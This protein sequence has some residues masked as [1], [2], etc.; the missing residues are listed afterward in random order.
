MQGNLGTLLDWQVS[1]NISDYLIVLWA[2]QENRRQYR[3]LF[4]TA[5]IGGGVSGAILFEVYKALRPLPP[6]ANAP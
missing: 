1:V 4:Y 3:E 5:N 2:T 6:V